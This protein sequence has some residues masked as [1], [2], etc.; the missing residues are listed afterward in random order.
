M[1]L[2]QNDAQQGILHGTQLAGSGGGRP[3]KP[4]AGFIFTMMAAITMWRQRLRLVKQ[5]SEG[6]DGLQLRLSLTGSTA[7]ITKT[8]SPCTGR[9]HR[10]RKA[11]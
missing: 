1:L 7:V 4:D 10:R 11:L 5:A 6:E 8:E 9:R 2:F 3:D